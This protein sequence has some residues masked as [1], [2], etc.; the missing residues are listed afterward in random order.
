MVEGEPRP[1]GNHAQ[2][3]GFV[4]SKRAA[5]AAAKH[6]KAAQLMAGKRRRDQEMPDAPRSDIP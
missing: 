3:I 1:I 2:E 5:S 4:S 6:Q